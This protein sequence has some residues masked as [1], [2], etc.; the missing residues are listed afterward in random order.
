MLSGCGAGLAEPDETVSVLE[1]APPPLAEALY[2]VDQPSPEVERLKVLLWLRS[3]ELAEAQLRDFRGASVTLRE[4]LVQRDEA[5]ASLK[6]EQA[7]AQA[8]LVEELERRVLSGDEVGAVE[9]PSLDPRPV[10]TAYVL[11]ALDQGQQLVDGLGPEQRPAM[12]NA[13][14]LLR[15]RLSPQEHRGLLGNPWADGDFATM[16]R[17]SS[18]DQDALDPGGL[19]TLDQG[20]SHLTAELDDERLVV[21]VALALEHEQLVP[22]VDLLLSR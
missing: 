9:L 14:F 18:G 8:P 13:L 17:S 12:A 1:E 21:L 20:Q 11:T 15:P 10:L 3:L 16:R 6:E 2:G 22:A 5:L 7:Q 4:A 19:F